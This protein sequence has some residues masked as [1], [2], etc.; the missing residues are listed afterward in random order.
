[1]KMMAI[2]T[3][4]NVGVTFSPVFI[5]FLGFTTTTPPAVVKG[6][7]ITGEPGL[8]CPNFVP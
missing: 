8:N 2:S 5:G 4:V 1:M 7:R 6:D 3:P